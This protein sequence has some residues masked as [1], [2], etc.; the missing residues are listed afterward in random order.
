VLQGIRR[1][2]RDE[3]HRRMWR[4]K[5]QSV[6][7]LW[8]I[9]CRVNSVKFEEIDDVYLP[10]STSLSTSWNG[11]IELVVPKIGTT[12]DYLNDHLFSSDRS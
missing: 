7:T 9:Y 6:R 8:S 3:Q 1:S 10:L 12:I 5:Y 4:P 2:P 11:K